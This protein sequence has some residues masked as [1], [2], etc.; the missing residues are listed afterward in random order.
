[1]GGVSSYCFCVLSG[2]RIFKGFRQFSYL[3]IV[4]HY[5]YLHV[6]CP[7]AIVNCTQVGSAM[8]CFIVVLGKIV[9]GLRIAT[10]ISMLV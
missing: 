7:V 9:D 10:V 1:M 2:G 6:P 5:T 3:F 8:A 4:V